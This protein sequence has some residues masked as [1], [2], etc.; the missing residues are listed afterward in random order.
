M[1]TKSH[2]RRPR[3]E[4]DGKTKDRLLL[5]LTH[6]QFKDGLLEAIATSL[7]FLSKEKKNDYFFLARQRRLNTAQE[8]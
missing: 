2:H 7:S 4:G 8:F 5:L 1:P 3:K 6:S